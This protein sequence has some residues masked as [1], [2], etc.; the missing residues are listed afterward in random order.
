MVA[1]EVADLVGADELE[2]EVPSLDLFVAEH[3]ADQ[4]GGG[5]DV[6]LRAR[7]VGDLDL[8]HRSYFCRCV[9]VSSACSL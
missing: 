4:I 5:V 1:L 9:P 8:D 2:P 6:E 3:G 7:A